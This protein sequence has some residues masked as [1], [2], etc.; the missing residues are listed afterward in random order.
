MALQFD[1]N[2]VE[3]KQCWFCGRKVADCD[4]GS[5]G[6]VYIAMTDRIFYSVRRVHH[7][8]VVKMW[9]FADKEWPRRAEIE[10]RSTNEIL[11]KLFEAEQ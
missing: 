8:C 10:R 5:I 11:T 3:N 6:P 2:K 1:I 9:K 4:V 7:S